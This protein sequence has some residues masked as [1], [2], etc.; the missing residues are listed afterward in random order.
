M[1]EVKPA[2]EIT[3]VTLEN[4]TVIH[5]NDHVY[6]APEHLGEP[7][8]I[9]RVM[10]F[11]TSH[12][13]KGLQARIAWYN[14]LKDVINRKSADPCLLVAT[15]HSDVNPVSSIRGKCTVTHKYYIPK[16]EFEAYRKEPDNFYYHQLYDRYIQRVYDVVPCETVQ[17]VPM[18]I[19]EA[20]KQRYQFIV[21]EQGKAAD[22]TVARRTCCVCN[23]WCQSTVS[24]KCT[25]CQKSYH[26]A[27]LN[28]P[29]TRKPSKGFAW[30]CAFCTRQELLM[31]ESLSSSSNPQSPS[32]DATSHSSAANSLSPPGATHPQQQQENDQHR[33]ENSRNKRQARTTR[34]QTKQQQRLSTPSTTPPPLPTPPQTKAS[35]VLAPAVSNSTNSSN[36]ASPS[37]KLKLN[38]KRN[39]SSAVSTPRASPIPQNNQPMKMTH[40]WPF[41]YFGINTNIGDILDVDDRIYP[42][43]KSRIGSRYQAT[44]A[45]SLSTTS[46]ADNNSRSSALSSPTSSEANSVSH[47]SLL[48]GS[49]KSR[50]SDKKNQSHNKMNNISIMSNGPHNQKQ[51]KPCDTT[52]ADIAMDI[53]SVSNNDEW[54]KPVR[55]GDDTVTCMYKPDVLSDEQVDDYMDSVR[56]LPNLPL[57]THNSDLLDRALLELHNNSYHTDIAFENM[58]KLTTED[59]KGEVV[60]QWSQEEINLFEQSIREHG[61]DL[62]YAKKNVKTKPM[63][64]IVRFFYQWKKTNRYEIVYSEWTKIYKPLKKFKKY[65]VSSENDKDDVIEEEMAKDEDEAEDE[66]LDP[67]IIPKT[68]VP[69]RK[70]YQCMNC[71]NTESRVWRRSPSDIDRRQKVFTKVLCDDC[72]VYWL[73]YAK[74]KPI[75]PQTR[76]A[77]IN[78]A[79]ARQSSP[80]NSSIASQSPRSESSDIVD[81][82]KRKRPLESGS[83]HMIKKI[84]DERRQRQVVIHF[85]PSPCKICSST[86]PDDRLYTCHSCGMSV[87][88]DCYGIDS[89]KARIGWRC[90]VCNN[91]RNPVVSYA[92]NCLLCN[93]KGTPHQPLKRTAG[94]HWVHLHCAAFI[95]EIKFANITTLTPVEYIGCLHPGRI[96]ANCQLCHDTRGACV[97]CSECRK[98]VHVQCAV[99]NQFKLAFEI[100]P[101]TRN[102]NKFTN[103]P[104][105]P[106]GLFGRGSPS[107]L[108]VPHVFCPSHNSIISHKKL[109]DLNCRTVNDTQESALMTYFKLYKQVAAD[110]TP[111]MRRFRATLNSRATKARHPKIPNAKDAA[112]EALNMSEHINLLSYHP[113]LSI[114]KHSSLLSLSASASKSLSSA[115][116]NTPSSSATNS[117]SSNSNNIV[118]LSATNTTTYTNPRKRRVCAMED[119]QIQHTPIWWPK[120]NNN[121]NENSEEKICNRCYKKLKQLQ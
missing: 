56:E 48:S 108:M 68:A 101:N 23:E 69:P 41:R 24:V 63:A 92:Y 110:T 44:V 40:M 14:R 17:N 3:E 58:S 35:V 36:S 16:N 76:I 46:I 95:P 72:G 116:A 104:M 99:N 27:C 39:D 81:N 61:H 109:I 26:M 75:S 79:H 10:E 37:L 50:K 62:N 32:Y 119:C 59:F 97:A 20:L 87:H 38:I 65:N 30:Q 103:Y 115:S 8:Y 96:E 2:H 120:S 114:K 73:K 29:L 13:R 45:D 57:P 22:L 82:K 4:G 49:S 94:H 6:L 9:G 34:S 80:S 111:A 118:N 89:R 121:D 100:L 52:T 43:A 74:I 88:N 31:A 5:I 105:V 47:L 1:S 113:E 11:C 7:Y 55:G 51:K 106:A 102:S 67:T 85:P 77:H 112:I 70:P 78:T 86:T 71:L 66:D 54:S 25:A 19:L 28:P 64:D 98:T 107:G 93:N 53:D 83:K 18:D 15:M 117:S 91:K 84:K 60:P 21:V 12:K 42:R 90:D 33:L